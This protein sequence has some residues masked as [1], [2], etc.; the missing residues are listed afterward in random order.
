MYTSDGCFLQPFRHSLAPKRK[1]EAGAQILFPVV[2]VTV[3][4]SL[5]LAQA[6]SKQHASFP[7]GVMINLKIVTEPPMGISHF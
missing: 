4:V 2:H 7:I 5:F 6:L 3:P 1:G